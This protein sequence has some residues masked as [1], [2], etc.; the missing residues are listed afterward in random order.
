MLLFDL[1]A[2]VFQDVQEEQTEYQPII[3]SIDPGFDE[4]TATKRGNCSSFDFFS[5]LFLGFKFKFFLSEIGWS[6]PM[7]QR[8]LLRTSDTPVK[9]NHTLKRS[10]SKAKNE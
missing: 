4:P 10:Q 5:I 7:H 2:S 6:L 8:F 1:I 3:I 9:E